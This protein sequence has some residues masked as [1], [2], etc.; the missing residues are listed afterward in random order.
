MM[1]KIRSGTVQGAA[2]GQI[3]T[4]EGLWCLSQ[5]FSTLSIR[6]CQPLPVDLKAS[7]TS[8][9]Y[10]IVADFL[11]GSADA[12]LPR[13]MVFLPSCRL[14]LSKNA[15]SSSGASSGSTQVLFKSFNFAFISFPHRNNAARLTALCPDHNYKPGIQ[16]AYGD[17][18]DFSVV[19]P[20]IF[21]GKVKPSKNLIG[22]GEIDT[23]LQQRF[24][25]FVLIEFNFHLIIVVT[26]IAK[27][28]VDYL[29]SGSYSSRAAAK[30]VVGRENPEIL[31]AHN[32]ACGFFMCVAL[33]HLSMVGRAGQPK[34]WPGSVG[35]GFSPLYVSPPM[36][37]RNLGGELLKLPT[38]DAT[39]ATIPPRFIF[40]FRAV[41]NNDPDALPVF[42]HSR[43]NT[44]RQARKP[45]EP[46][47]QLE[48]IECHR[49]VKSNRPR[50]IRE[51]SQ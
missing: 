37:V 51:V 3:F 33:L 2:K 17:V 35:T 20:F 45:H 10:R 38:E 32:R 14:A 49:R 9:E 43:A 40:I 15:S 36:I 44:E 18:S 27:S 5:S 6:V 34:G 12:G 46:F 19:L 31:T 30:S 7:I 25:P 4:S 39:M 50:I 29:I 41:R 23:A 8:G 47:Y 11:V 1:E 21:C 26:L 24:I 28:N 42:L 13:R 22:S 16:F 48:L